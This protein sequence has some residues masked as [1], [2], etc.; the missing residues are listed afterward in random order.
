MTNKKQ[1]FWKPGNIIVTRGDIQPE[2]YIIKD[3]EGNPIMKP[4]TLK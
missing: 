1:Q 4:G 3:A 2:Y